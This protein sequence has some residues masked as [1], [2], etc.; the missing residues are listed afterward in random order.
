M[1][2]HGNN[3]KEEK[4]KLFKCNLCEET[5]S[6]PNILIKHLENQHGIRENE[7]F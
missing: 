5:F 4:C 1:N 2:V 7:N 6:I 3:K